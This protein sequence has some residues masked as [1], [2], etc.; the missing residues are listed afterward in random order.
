VHDEANVRRQL[1]ATN[2]IR[3]IAY[4]LMAILGTIILTRLAAVAAAHS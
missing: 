1:I 4:G 3:T 2:W